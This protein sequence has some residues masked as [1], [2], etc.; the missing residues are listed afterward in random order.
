M[1]VLPANKSLFLQSQTNPTHDWETTQASM[2]VGAEVIPNHF[3]M[4]GYPDEEGILI[5][6]GRP[7]QALG[8]TQFEVSFTV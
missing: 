1:V 4:L 8:Q 3:Y 5:N 6:G 2:E 7:G